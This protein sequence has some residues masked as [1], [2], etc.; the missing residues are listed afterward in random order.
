MNEKNFL[1][2]PYEKSRENLDWNK[3]FEALKLSSTIEAKSENEEEI[4]EYLK[5]RF[6]SLGIVCEQDEK[7]NLWFQSNAPEGEIMLCAHMDK[8][9]S[10]KAVIEVDENIQGRL[11]DILGVNMIMDI[12]QRGYRPSVLFTV[13][14]ECQEEIVNADGKTSVVFREIKDDIYNA[15]AR[16][17]AEALEKGARKKPKL[18]VVIDTSGRA[19]IG[20]APLVYQSSGVSENDVFPFPNEPLKGVVKLLNKNEVGA[21]VMHGYANDSIEFSFVKGVGVC[22]I[23]VPINNYHSDHEVASKE[24]V[25]K[26]IRAIEIIL[27]NH[28]EIKLPQKELPHQNTTKVADSIKL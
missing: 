9:G 13:E 16:A 24:D 1:Q 12:L 5:S 10:A 26:S 23:E 19:E 4:R 27:Q 3:F 28:K 20:E 15:G 14:E 6:E 7:G 21:K 25:Q 8:I 17:A 18:I 11:D 22:A 2:I